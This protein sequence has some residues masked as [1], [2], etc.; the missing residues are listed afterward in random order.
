MLVGRNAAS[1]TR[2][3]AKFTDGTNNLASGQGQIPAVTS[4]YTQIGLSAIAT[5][6]GTSTISFQA[7]AD[8]SSCF[9]RPLAWQ[10]A[11]GSTATMMQAIKIA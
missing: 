7:A 5:Y 10:N 11:A 2:F 6:G 3:T 1:T 4:T 9:I 8:V